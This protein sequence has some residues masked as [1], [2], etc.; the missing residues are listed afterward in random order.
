MSTNRWEQIDT[1]EI[2]R[3]TRGPLPLDI[4]LFPTL[5]MGKSYA[6]R[7]EWFSLLLL[8]LLF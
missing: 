6:A 1:M 8:P 4:V 5:H 3:T 2:R 7:M